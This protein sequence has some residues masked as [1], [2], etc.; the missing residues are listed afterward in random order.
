MKVR[1]E[2]RATKRWGSLCEVLLLVMLTLNF[3]QLGVVL[4]WRFEPAVPPS[5]S[6]LQEITDL[7]GVPK[8][9]WRAGETMYIHSVQRI[10]RDVPRLAVQ[11]IYD[12][13]RQIA[14]VRFA[15]LASP[16]IKPDRSFAVLL[17]TNLPPGNYTHRV[18]IIYALNPL[19]TAE[20]FDLPSVPFRVVK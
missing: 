14:A 3:G 12:E 13:D 17:P 6:V 9:D 4:W 10:L 16:T 2:R 8:S 1:P 18:E 20:K 7:N 15:P 19:R 5:I 11:T